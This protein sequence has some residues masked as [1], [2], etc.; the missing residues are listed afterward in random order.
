MVGTFCKKR[1]RRGLDTEGYM[2]VMTEEGREIVVE[3][4]MSVQALWEN[5]QKSFKMFLLLL[6][7]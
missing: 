3:I 1:L 6:S 5:A 7:D 4:I 2:T